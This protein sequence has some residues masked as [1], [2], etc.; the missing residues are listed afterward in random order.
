VIITDWVVLVHA[1]IARA[2]LDCCEL[3]GHLIGVPPGVLRKEVAKRKRKNSR[4]NKPEPASAALDGGRQETGADYG[5]DGHPTPGKLHEPYLW[6][7][8]P[9]RVGQTEHHERGG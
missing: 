2:T 3:S 5:N 8:A 1:F 9:E 6:Q 4:E 7:N